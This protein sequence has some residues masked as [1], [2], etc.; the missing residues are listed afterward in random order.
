RVHFSDDGL[1]W[2]ERAL[3]PTGVSIGGVA[4][5]PDT[6]TFVGVTA[7][8][9]NGYAAQRFYRSQDGIAWEQLPTSATVQSHP[10]LGISWGRIEAP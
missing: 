9:F 4:F 8:Y 5:S 6:G 1:S 7:G 10:I 3:T 2:H